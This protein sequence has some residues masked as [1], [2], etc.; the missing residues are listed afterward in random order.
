[1]VL[2]LSLW[3]DVLTK[4]NWL[5]SATPSKDGKRTAADPGVKRGPC[6]MTAGDPLQLRGQYPSAHVL[7]T[8]IMVGE[9][10]STFTPEAAAMCA[11][12]AAAVASW[13]LPEAMATS[14]IRSLVEAHGFR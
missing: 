7:Y 9:L 14:S 1:M 8:N 12:S 2:V 6:T 5:D 3:D 13:L 11:T 4:M 10:G